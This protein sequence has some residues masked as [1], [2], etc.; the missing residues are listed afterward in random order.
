MSPAFSPRRQGGGTAPT[1]E[2]AAFTAVVYVLTSGCAWRMLPSPVHEMD[3]SGPMATTTVRRARRARQ[4]GVARLVA[5]RGRRCV[6][7]EAKGGPIAGANPVDRGKSG[8]KL[9]VLSDRSGIPITV[10]VSAANT[11]DAEALRPL[12]RTIPA[13]WSTPA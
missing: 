13:A 7:F 10:A 3:R 5:R 12:V 11:P 1:D 6:R 4:S 2:R 8:S 9:H